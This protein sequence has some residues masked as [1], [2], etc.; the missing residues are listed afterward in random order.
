[1]AAALLTAR[2]AGTGIDAT[3]TSAG[4]FPGGMPPAPGAAEVMARRG[5]D[6]T[7]HRSRTV[8][9]ELAADSDLVLGMER[10][11]IREVAVL[12][13]DQ[14]ERTFT[15]PELLRRGRVTGPRHGRPLA[16]WL[17]EVADGREARALL[18]DDPVDEVADPIGGPIREFVATARQ[19][20]ELCAEL[21][22]LL[23]A[24]VPA[25]TSAP[26]ER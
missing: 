15:L 21:V 19:L 22:D 13:S 5:I 16:T 1:M 6:I 8:S 9:P 12:R 10:R 18:A 11:H 4:L 14:L 3:V 17:S 7:G 23:W 2:L 25:P 24:S 26:V 20:D